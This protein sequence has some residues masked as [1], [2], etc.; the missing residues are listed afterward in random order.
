MEFL[1]VQFALAALLTLL[2]LVVLLAGFVALNDAADRAKPLRVPVF[3]RVR[4]ARVMARPLTEQLAAS[5]TRAPPPRESGRAGYT[6]GA[7]P[8]S[9]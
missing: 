9:R 8:G 7:P 6:P 5:P 3:G 4:E 2:A 1:G